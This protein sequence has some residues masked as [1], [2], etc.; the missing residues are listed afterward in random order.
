M[1]VRWSYIYGERKKKNVTYCQEKM[2]RNKCACR[3][4]ICKTVCY[5]I[6]EIRGK[7]F[8]IFFNRLLGKQQ[9][10]N[11]FIRNITQF[12][13]IKYF[14]LSYTDACE[15]KTLT[16]TKEKQIL[17]VARNNYVKWND[18]FGLYSNAICSSLAIASTN[19]EVNME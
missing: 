2:M 9:K 5:E 11:R 18:A 19:N 16:G 15:M 6:T 7:N 4:Q 10:I 13:W 8:A 1:R 17:C 14:S 12:N 3:K